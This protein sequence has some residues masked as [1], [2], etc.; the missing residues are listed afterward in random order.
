MHADLL[1]LYLGPIGLQPAELAKLGM[2]LWGADVIARKGPALGHWRELA[3]PLFP[4]SACC[5]CWSA[6]TTWAPCWCCSR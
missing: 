1:W 2:V 5:S 6:T 4:W 3:R